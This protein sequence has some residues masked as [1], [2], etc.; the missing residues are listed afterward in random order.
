[1]KL[2]RT[3]IAVLRQG[4]Q[5]RKAEASKLAEINRRIAFH[6]MAIHLITAGRSEE[7][8]GNYP[9]PTEINPD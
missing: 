9:P 8:N 5:E 3:L 7:L 6:R 2:I 1:M 4:K